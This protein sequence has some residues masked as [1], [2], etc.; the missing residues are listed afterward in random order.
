MNWKCFLLGHDWN[1]NKKP[2]SPWPPEISG[3]P[4]D[5]SAVCDRCGAELF[6]NQYGEFDF[7]SKIILKVTNKEDGM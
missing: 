6:K 4:C 2:K 5:Y 1:Y 3:G 7:R